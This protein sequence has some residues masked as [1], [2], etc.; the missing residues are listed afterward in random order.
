MGSDTEKQSVTTMESDMTMET[1][2]SEATMAA[3]CPADV[4]EADRAMYPACT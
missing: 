1:D 3:E 2:M 4:S